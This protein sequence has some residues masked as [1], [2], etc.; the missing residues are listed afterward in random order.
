MSA[1]AEFWRARV[2]SERRL[3]VAGAALVALT[4]LYLY[5]W[6]PVATERT[7]LIA[8]LP[9]LRAQAAALERDAAE[10]KRLRARSAP[11]F[12]EL[13][14]LL[15]QAF[16]PDGSDDNSPQVRRMPGGRIEVTVE[17]RD[18]AV[19]LTG[20]ARVHEAQGLRP[21]TVEIELLQSR[22]TVRAAAT[23]GGAGAESRR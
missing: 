7:R 10:V 22:G 3:L 8:Q 6:L 4:A 15:K 18:P 12:E 9:L 20:V 1:L 16:A 23:Y 11:R 17:S 5:V 13:E 21:E 19:W 2:Q 14:S